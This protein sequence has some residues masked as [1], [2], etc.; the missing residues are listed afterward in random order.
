M[1]LEDL[2]KQA[3][4]AAED[5]PFADSSYGRVIQE[6]DDLLFGMNAIERM[7]LSVG[8][9]LI[10]SILSFLVLLLSGSIEV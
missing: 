10:V 7:F 9:F 2:R 5:D 3:L 6:E 1:S 8:L 4:E